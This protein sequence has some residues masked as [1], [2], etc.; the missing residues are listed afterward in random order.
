M[1]GKLDLPQR[2]GDFFKSLGTLFAGFVAEHLEEAVLGADP[3]LLRP[4][5][6][7]DEFAFLTACTRCDKC[8]R[9]CPQDSIV[10]AS[11]SARFAVGTPFISPRSM[12]C[13]LCTELPCIPACPEG[14]LVWPRLS[15]AGIDREGPR[16]VRMGLAEI[17]VATCLTWPTDERGAQSCRTCVDRC[18][19]PGE[20]IR[21]IEGG[22]GEPAHPRVE[23]EIC[24]GCGLCE[25]GCPT[26]KAS[27]VVKPRG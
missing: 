22:E 17:N 25:F 8:I 15:V 13:F 24:T 12:P 23:A 2:R 14:A 4:P 11:G 19:Y 6:A 27:I 5:G 20:A 7:L 18:P 1:A 26:P 9:A 10:K 21:L 16:A 3:G